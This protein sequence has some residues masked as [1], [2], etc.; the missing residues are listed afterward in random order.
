MEKNSRE[1]PRIVRRDTAMGVSDNYFGGHE[2]A[3][4]PAPQDV[5]ELHGWVLA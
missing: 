3:V 4:L 5:G 1:L 2:H